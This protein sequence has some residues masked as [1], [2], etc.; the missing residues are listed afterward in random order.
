VTCDIWASEEM[1]AGGG[2]AG[3]CLGNLSNISSHLYRERIVF[4]VGERLAGGLFHI[5]GWSLRGWIP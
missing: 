2:A 1:G 3:G 5:L 4:S